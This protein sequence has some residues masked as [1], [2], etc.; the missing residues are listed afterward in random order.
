MTRGLQNSFGINFVGSGSATP[1]QRIKNDE[2]GL[3]VD[4]NDSWIRSRTGISERRVIGKDEELTG[5]SACAA[6]QAIKMAGWDPGTVDLIIIVAL[7][8]SFEISSREAS[9]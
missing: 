5:L 7:T 9:T 3:R 4:T 1:S 8:F 2:L 6:N